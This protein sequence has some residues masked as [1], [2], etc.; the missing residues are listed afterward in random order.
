MSGT[1]ND[2]TLAAYKTRVAALT[3]TATPARESNSVTENPPFIST[4]GSAANYLSLDPAKSTRAA[5]GGTPV[6][7]TVDYLNNTRSTTKPDIGAYEGPF[8]P[9]DLGVSALVMP[10]SPLCP[11]GS[12]T[13]TA[14]VKNFSA[15]SVT[16]SAAVVLKVTATRTKP[17]SSTVALSYSVPTGTTIAAGGTLDVTFVPAQ[18]FSASGTYTLSNLTTMLTDGQTPASTFVESSS[19]NNALSPAPSLTVRP[20]ATASAGNS[21]AA[22]CPGNGYTTTGSFGGSATSATYT[23]SGTGSFSNGGVIDSSTPSV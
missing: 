6:S 5:D 9:Y 23:S 10:T 18:D 4:T 12:Q 3:P 2:Q 15:G 1:T 19:T 16:T 20:N 8:V 13:I 14:M 7:V 17:N 22:I 21:P 11:N